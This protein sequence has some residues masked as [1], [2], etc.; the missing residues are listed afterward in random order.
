MLLVFTARFIALEVNLK[1]PAA[2]SKLLFR[3]LILCIILKIRKYFKVVLNQ[4]FQ[5]TLHAA[6]L[7]IRDSK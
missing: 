2:L 7:F 6:D 5:K 3:K 1:I 4:T